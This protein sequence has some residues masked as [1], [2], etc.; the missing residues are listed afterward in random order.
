MVDSSG[1]VSFA[2]T[3]YR[4]GN[5]FIGETAGVRLVGDTVQISIDGALIRTHRA[6]SSPAP[7]SITTEAERPSGLEGS[8]VTATA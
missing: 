1:G 2:G 6:R 4:V 8:L 3:M 7:S 5:R